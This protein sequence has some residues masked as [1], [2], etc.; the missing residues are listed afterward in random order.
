MAQLY[1]EDVA[2]GTEIT[3][4]VK[5]PTTDQLIRWMGVTG[6]VNR[7]H[8]DK[9]FALSAGWPGTIVHGSLK[10]QFLI[11]MLTDWIGHGGT[12]RKVNCQNRGM[13]LPGNTLICKGRVVNKYVEGEHHY[14]EC[15]IYIDN[16]KGE[17]TTAGKALIVVPC[18]SS[19]TN[20]DTATGTPAI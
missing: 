14:L 16:H 8:Y 13:D 1:Y 15:E 11:Q 19:V 18:R 17:R 20:A 12:I 6:D 2:V 3:P 10:W 5:L 4:L 7:I 9:E